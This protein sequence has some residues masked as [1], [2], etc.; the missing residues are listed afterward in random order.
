MKKQKIPPKYQ[1]DALHEAIL[2]LLQISYDPYYDN[3]A[4]VSFAH[5]HINWAISAWRRT[6]LLP[7]TITRQENPEPQS[8]SIEEL[9]GESLQNFIIEAGL[10][11][12]DPF[13]LLYAPKVETPENKLKIKYPSDSEKLGLKKIVAMKKKGLN[14]QKIADEIGVTTRTIQRRMQLLREFNETAE[15]VNE[16]N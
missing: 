12:S 10:L 13:A 3:G 16:N 15:T 11:A 8:M 5:R 1:S 6:N 9:F 4:I 2:A 7:V 14:N